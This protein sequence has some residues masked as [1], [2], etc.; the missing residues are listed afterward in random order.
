MWWQFGI[1]PHALHED[2]SEFFCHMFSCLTGGNGRKK[3][4]A[5]EDWMSRHIKVT[6]VEDILGGR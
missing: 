2:V 6:T 4:A 1:R 3:Q 5:L